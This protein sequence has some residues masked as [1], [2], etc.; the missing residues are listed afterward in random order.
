MLSVRYP[1]AIE[2][3]RKIKQVMFIS[4]FQTLRRV[5]DTHAAFSLIAGR[6]WI[7]HFSLDLPACLNTLTLALV[8]EGSDGPPMVFR[9]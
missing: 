4:N 3:C 9:E 2:Q 5:G 6:I 1:N 7:S 8:G